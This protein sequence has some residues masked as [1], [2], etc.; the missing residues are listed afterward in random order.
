MVDSAADNMQATL[1]KIILA[2]AMESRP[3]IISSGNLPI[4]YSQGDKSQSTIDTRPDYYNKETV[5]TYSA[6]KCED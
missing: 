1:G 4:T 5:N 3:N 2:D 6:N